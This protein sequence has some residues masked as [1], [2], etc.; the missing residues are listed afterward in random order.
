MPLPSTKNSWKEWIIVLLAFAP[1]LFINVSASHDWGDDFAQYIFQAKCLVEGKSQST[2]AITDPAFYNVLGPPTRPIG[3]PLLLAPLYYFFGNNLFVFS[4]L[5]S[6]CY[7]LIAIFTFRYLRDWIAFFPA[8]LWTATMIYNPQFLQLKLAV[9]SD[10]PF[11][12]LLFIFF[13]IARMPLN[14][15]HIIWLGVIAGFMIC[16][17][18]I[19]IVLIPVYIIYWLTNKS[20]RKSFSS[21]LKQP[22]L[23]SAVSTLLFFLLN[24]ILFNATSESWTA[25]SF[26]S[27][28]IDRPTLLNTVHYYTFIFTLI[29]EQE[30]WGFANI[31]Q[32]SFMLSL[33]LIGIVISFS[34]RIKIEDWFV[35][36]Y[37]GAM[38][39]YP[40]C[41]AAIRF[42]MPVFPMLMLYQTETLNSLQIPSYRLN[43]LKLIII[44]FIV[45]LSYKINLQ[46]IVQQQGV[47]QEG[48]QEKY[49]AEAF[50]FI[51]K[52]LPENQT[53]AFAQHHAFILYTQRKCVPY[54]GFQTADEMNFLFEKYNVSYLLYIKNVCDEEVLNLTSVKN[55]SYKLIWQN[56]NCKLFEHL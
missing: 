29:Y 55:T 49:A 34:K 51:N 35:M 20:I 30:V 6:L 12:V 32:K 22:V 56:N 23:F 19:G 40:S 31:I 7:Y 21:F 39:L 45:L 53:Y 25:Y 8:L 44:P 1:V 41:S 3:L 9:L 28:M 33:V 38:F 42:L 52:N 13:R 11:I 37:L 2:L 16:L 27:G 26:I 10:L 46:N 24:N 15:K 50:D 5:M 18:L 48:P 47:V 43:N 36:I 4:C 14:T 17:R 54:R